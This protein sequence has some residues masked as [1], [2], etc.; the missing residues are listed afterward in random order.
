[1]RRIASLGILLVATSLASAEPGWVF[2][3]VKLRSG[4]G[5]KHPVLA[6]IPD[7]TAVDMDQCMKG[8]CAVRWKRL[9]GYVYIV[10]MN[11]M[12]EEMACLMFGE[13]DED[14]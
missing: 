12:T 2:D 9:K 8:W 10:D 4:P 11:V 1:M 14:C 7:G 13:E 3:A 6:T 5:N